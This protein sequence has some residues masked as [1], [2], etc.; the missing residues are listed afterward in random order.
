MTTIIVE[1]GNTFNSK[2][3]AKDFNCLWIHEKNFLNSFISVKEICRFYEIPSYNFCGKGIA[4]MIGRIIQNSLGMNHMLMLDADINNI[5]NLR[6]VEKILG[7]HL[8]FRKKG[9]IAKHVLLATPNRKNDGLH[10][11][12]EGIIS[13]IT[14]NSNKNQ[15]AKLI[16]EVSCRRELIIN[17]I[18]SQLDSNLQRLA[19]MHVHL[20]PL[21]H[22]LT[23][24]RFL[25][26]DFMTSMPCIT[27]SLE[28][29][30]NIHAAESNV[31]SYQAGNQEVLNDAK[32]SYE[33]NETMLISCQKLLQSKFT[34]KSFSLWDTEDYRLF[35]RSSTLTQK[36]GLLPLNSNSP[37]LQIKCT[38][39]YIFPSIGKLV[40]LGFISKNVTIN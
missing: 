31:V 3:I 17:D 25:N 16:L 28:T 35:N 10:S 37:L 20:S 36:V 27:N 4:Q 23:G 22:L 39:D 9:R 34:Y 40:D 5:D 14:S 15:I 19:L 18:V 29:M 26:R 33:K 2:N 6:P 24:E 21:I 7:T 8:Y 38:P 30:I 12:L 13:N 11:F 1:G 32:N